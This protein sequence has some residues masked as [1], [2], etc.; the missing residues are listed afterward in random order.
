MDFDTGTLGM[1]IRIAIVGFGKIAQDEHLPAIAATP[2]IALTAIASPGA[3]WDGAPCYDS[4]DAL[5][6]GG[7]D[8]DAAAICTPPQ[9]RRA[10]AAQ[11]LAHGKHVLLEKPPTAS[12]REID[13]LVAAAEAAGV[14]LFAT[15]HSRFAAGVEPARAL[16]A[17]RQILSVAV[18]WKEDVDIWHPGQSWI[19]EPGGMGVFDPGINA[20]S[21]LTHILPR[22]F[23]LTRADLE[24]P[25][26]RA[27][28]IAAE[29]AFADE[30]GLPIRCS[31]DFREKKSQVWDIMIETDRGRITL[32]LGG[33]RL[34]LDGIVI[35]DGENTEYRQI[36]GR[37]V[38]LIA[39]RDRDADCVPFVHVADAFMLGHRH[40]VS[41]WP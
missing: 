29:L 6:A 30:A 10:L 25:E 20:L 8:F 34:L 15:W 18:H 28:P 17:D 5:L 24:I 36:Y 38:D 11:A 41:S 35:I 33:A 37:F 3:S 40:I 2:G 26:G 22:P 7:P 13:T 31:F 12:L 14:T 39:S 21:I 23:F 16:L 19:W 32:S 1:T 4:L 9:M 27:A